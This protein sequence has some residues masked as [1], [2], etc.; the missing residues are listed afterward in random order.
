MN[1]NDRITDNFK[2]TLEYRIDNKK[3]TSEDEIRF[4]N[5]LEMAKEYLTSW[6]ILH[7]KNKYEVKK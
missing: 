5:Q 4:I 6:E 1:L 3:Y 7:Y 2:E